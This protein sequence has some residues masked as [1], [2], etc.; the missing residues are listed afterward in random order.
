MG[1]GTQVG[2]KKG[3]SSS[4]SKAG[5]RSKDESRCGRDRR[6]MCGGGRSEEVLDGIQV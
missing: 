3:D 4:G 6:G 2:R 1:F 5:R